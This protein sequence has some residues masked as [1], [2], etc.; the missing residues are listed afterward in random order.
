MSDVSDMR[1][2]RTAEGKRK[3]GVSRASNNREGEALAV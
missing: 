3:E 2:K 1:Q